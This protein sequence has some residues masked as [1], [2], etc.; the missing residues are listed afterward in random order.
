[1]KGP[2][3]IES[4]VVAGA[5]L[6]SACSSSSPS[7][8]GTGGTGG[9]GGA[10]GATAG[11]SGGTAGSIGTAGVTTIGTSG[12]TVSMDGVT[13]TIPAG[14]LAADTAIAVTTTAAPSG[15]TLASSAYKFSP[16]GT[17]FAKAITVAIPLTSAATGAHLF[18]SNAANGYDD[19]GGTVNGTTL[20]GQVSHFSVGFAATPANDGGMADG[21]AGTSGQAGADGGSSDS[22]VQDAAPEAVPQSDDVMAYVGSW[23]I[24]S[25]VPGSCQGMPIGP[26][27]S[28]LMIRAGSTAGTIVI[29]GAA[30]GTYQNNGTGPVMPCADFAF[31][32]VG[33]MATVI[34]GSNHC[35]YDVGSGAGIVATT[36]T[37]KRTGDSIAFNATFSITQNGG[38]VTCTPSTSGTLTKN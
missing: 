11:T 23:N 26:Q 28:P 27:T 24:T 2:R 8:T 14:A 16:D 5:V 35:F 10:A 18:W 15:Y 6:V 33:T 9:S 20:T 34:G 17:T 36:F 30:F 4:V 31:D 19:L 13:L 7:K 29:D 21:S 22:S 37:M 1:M 32:V 12:G 3:W 25:V 38:I